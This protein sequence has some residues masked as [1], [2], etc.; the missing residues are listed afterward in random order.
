LFDWSPDSGPNSVSAD[1]LFASHPGRQSQIY[2]I[3]KRI[4]DIALSLCLSPVL[5]L[6]ALGLVICNPFLNPGRLLYVQDRMG[7]NCSAFRAVKFRSMVEAT[8]IER[9]PFDTLEHHRITRFGRFLRRSRLDELPQVINVLRG[10]MSLIGPR[11][12]YLGHAKAYVELVPGYRER[13]GMKPGISGFA[14]V[15]HGYVDGLDG[16]QNKVSADLYYIRNASIRFDIWITW[17]TFLTV[18]LHRGM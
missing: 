16:L 12:D 14:Q 6:T 9:G 13:H 7:R 17:R 3:F 11:P 2:L 4:F 18:V 5:V 1:N 15:A 10:E 8:A